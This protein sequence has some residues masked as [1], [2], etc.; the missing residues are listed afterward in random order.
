MCGQPLQPGPLDPG[1]R[2]G[3]QTVRPLHRQ[4]LL[5]TAT[6]RWTDGHTDGLRNGLVA[7][8]MAKWMDGQ[9]GRDGETDGEMNGQGNGHKDWLRNRWMEG[10]ED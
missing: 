9:I 1:G 10:Q 3:V 7:G 5:Q 2:G 8:R 4:G 6:D